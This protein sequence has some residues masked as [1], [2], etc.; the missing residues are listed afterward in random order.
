MVSVTSGKSINLSEFF[1]ISLQNGEN[2]PAGP[3]RIVV[4]MM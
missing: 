3:D 4:V 2:E 1:F